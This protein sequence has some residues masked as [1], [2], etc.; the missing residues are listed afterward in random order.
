MKT[1]EQNGEMRISNIEFNDK[2]GQ[3][4]H[5]MACEERSKTQSEL[6]VALS[7]INGTFDDDEEDGNDEVVEDADDECEVEFDGA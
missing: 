1:S 2:N 6:T 5:V 7:I 4:L 3:G